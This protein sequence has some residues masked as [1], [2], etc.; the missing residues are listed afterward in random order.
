MPQIFSPASNTIAKASI[1]GGFLLIVVLLSAVFFLGSTSYVT[2]ENQVRP[3]PVAFSHRHHVNQLGIDCRY[4]HTSV[5][6]SS[7]AGMPPTKTC[8]TCHSQIWTEAPI[9]EPVRESWR[10]GNSIEWVR[11]HDLPDYVYFNHSIHV[12]KG[13]G[14]ES[15]HGDLNEMTLT[16]QVHSLQM[17]WCLQCH[18]NPEAFI[19]DR[20]DVYKFESQ[21]DYTHPSDQTELGARLVQSYRVNKEQLEDCSVCHR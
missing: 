6:E 7:F 20:A 14:C 13:I 19:R 10:T 21:P 15:C 18:R 4:C 9:L 5:E 1:V 2:R 3:Q 8:M 11:V 17:M 12:R 16:R